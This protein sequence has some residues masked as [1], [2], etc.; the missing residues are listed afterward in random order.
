M[1]VKKDEHGNRYVEASV[2]VPGTPEDVWRAI[3]TGPGISS[4]FMPCKVDGREGGS[5]ITSYGPGMDAPATITK[6]N[7][8]LSYIVESEGGPDKV[9]SEWTIEARAG[10]TCL[11]RI[12]HRWFART[13][14]WDGEFEGHAYGWMSFFRIL[15]LYLAHYAGQPCSDVQL[16]AFSSNPPPQTWRTLKTA[17]RIDDATRRVT[18]APNAPELAGTI[19]DIIINDPEMLRARETAPQI[20]AALAGMEGE[21]PELLLHLDRPAPGIMHT[22]VMAMGEQTMVSIRIFFYGHQAATTA[23][24]TQQAWTNWLAAQFPQEGSP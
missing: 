2:E 15:H 10:G 8:P 20:V 4:W 6:W 24:A 13:D 5:V 18:S 7:P 17:L 16:S 23:A 12:V 21:N 11:V 1:P 9:A 22:F 3:A 19:E 14:D